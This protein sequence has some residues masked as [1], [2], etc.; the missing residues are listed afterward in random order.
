MRK[1]GLQL[2][3]SL[4]VALAMAFFIAAPAMADDDDPPTRVARLSHTDG[5]VSFEPAGTE[6]WVNAEINRPLTTGDK[7][8]ADNG[9]RASLHIGS[10][11]IRL[12]STT[13]FSFL[14]LSD[15]VAQLQ[16]T[17]GTLRIRVKRLDENETFE[18]DT[19]NLAFSVLR[20]GIYRI[21]VNEAG[22]TTLVTVF[23]GQGEVTGG[24]QAFTVHADETG[25]FT[26]TEQ[27]NGEIQQAEGYDDFDR[28]SADRDRRE[29]HSTS[30][31]YV[32]PDVI[33]Y[34]DLDDYG[35]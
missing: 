23:E 35:G 14:N 20:P 7:L 21:N 33:G 8:W 1:H 18:V 19:P 12:G 29:D 27:L 3:S 4:S 34:E 11:S 25:I 2:V 9:A 22:D 13:G 31:R 16:L 28:W 26:G 30:A 5:S 10:A 24:G 15:N 32:S 6:D 17:E